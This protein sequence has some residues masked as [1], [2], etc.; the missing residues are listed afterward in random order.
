[1]NVIPSAT[2]V[3][4]GT[5]VSYAIQITNTG[6]TLVK[7]VVLTDLLSSGVSFVS[8]T[9]TPSSSS[10][11]TIVIPVGD[12]PAGAVATIIIKENPSALGTFTSQFSATATTGESASLTETARGSKTAPVGFGG[13][14]F[15][16]TL[17]YVHA[18]AGV[19]QNAI[20][21]TSHTFTQIISGSH[22]G[23][24]GLYTIMARFADTKNVTR[25]DADLARL[26]HHIP[27]GAKNLLPTW[28]QTVDA[29]DLTSPTRDTIRTLAKQLQ[30]DLISYLAE[31]EGTLF[32]ILKSHGGN[33]YD[34]LLTFNGSVS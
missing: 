4:V 25:L 33:T 13:G 18:P 1:M 10:G 2:V 26:S 5:E 17:D 32:N 12:I 24:D 6:S 8:S 20:N 21:L 9:N 27:Y 14:R 15:D 11:S 16:S 29:T 30:H 19:S 28:Q 34:S 3:K 22:D 23:W 31:N 7:G